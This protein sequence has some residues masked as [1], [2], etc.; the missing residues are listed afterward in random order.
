MPDPG[1]RRKARE[2]AL[3]FLFG[4]EF[5]HGPWPEALEGFWR[6]APSRPGVRKYAETVIGGACENRE[7]LDRNIDG[8]LQN[9]AP[10]RVGRLER[11]ILRIAL[12]EMRHVADVPAAVAINEAIELAKSFGGEDAPRFIN[13]ILDR[14]RAD[15]G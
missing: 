3:Q 13:G 6:M 15:K 11:N 7:T 10:E 14:L 8:A 9:W 4:L 2:R 5:T 1:I 12:Y